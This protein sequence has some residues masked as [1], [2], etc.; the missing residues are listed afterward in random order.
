[1]SKL[2]KAIDELSRHIVTLKSISN[3]ELAWLK[4]EVVEMLQNGDNR[5]E[6]AY[7]F[8]KEQEDEVLNPYLK[9]LT[10]TYF[11]DN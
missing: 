9:E 3:P 8:I 5:R 6:L 10:S 11:G 1:M 7:D 4:R 2:D